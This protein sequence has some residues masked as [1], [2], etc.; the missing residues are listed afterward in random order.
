MPH[1]A[2]T[3]EVV[4][5][6]IHSAF[7]ALGLIGKNSNSEKWYVDSGASNHMMFAK[8]NLKPYHGDSKIHIADGEYLPI[9][10]V[11]NIPHAIPFNHVFYSSRLC[12]NLLSV[13]QLVDNNCNVL[14]SKSGCVVQDQDSGTVIG[15]GT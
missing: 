3:P 6:M 5:Q 11:G 15:E 8:S 14:I 12:F 7:S 2:I 9:E 13:G 10:S 1:N 4:Q